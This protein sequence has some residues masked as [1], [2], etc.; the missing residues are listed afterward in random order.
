[1]ANICE[2]E[3]KIV[4][5]FENMQ[6]FYEALTQENDIWIGRGAGDTDIRYDENKQS[7]I[8][9]GWVPWSIKSALVI[10]A[11]DMK[12]EKEINQLCFYDGIHQKK[13]ICNNCL[14][15]WEACKLYNIVMEV[16]SEEEGM[17]FQQHILCNKGKVEIDDT[18]DWYEYDEYDF[19]DYETKEEAEEGLKIVLSE[20][21]WQDKYVTSGGFK[22]WDFQI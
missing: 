10:A 17:Q 12:E 13:K 15:L 7:A 5:S 3:M 14:T 6:K 2:F 9:D 18:V 19:E 4:G 1:M 16:Y 20:E 8:I 11:N 21:E 22:N